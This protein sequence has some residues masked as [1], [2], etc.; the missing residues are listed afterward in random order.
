MQCDYCNNWHHQI[1]VLFNGR[2]NEGGEAPFTCPSCIMS[3]LEKKERTPTTTR[4]SSQL[5]ANVL[6]QTRLSYFLEERLRKVLSHERN[7]RA[8]LLGKPLEEVPSAEGLTIRVVSS[9]DKKLETKPGFYKAFKDQNYPAE[10]P[11]RSKVLLLFQKIEGV[12]VCLLGIYVQEYGSDCP[13]PNNRRVYLSYL[14]SVKYFRP[15]GIQVATGEGCALRTYCYHQILI[16]YLQYIKQ[17][18]FT[19]C[20]I[21][22]CPPFQG[23]DYI[24]YCHPKE[25]KTPKSEKLREWYLKMLRQAQKEGIVLSLSNLYDEFH[26]GNQNHDIASAAE[27]PYFDGDYFPG[28][29]EDWIPGIQK[30]Q[31][32]AAKKNKG[33]GGK[34]ATAAARKTGKGKRLGAGTPEAELDLELMKKLGTTIANMRQDFIMVHLA[35]QC[36]QCRK[37]IADD[38]RWYDSTPSAT[39]TVFELCQ[40]CYDVEQALPAHEKLLTGGR[41]LVCERVNEL[42]DMRE[43]GEVMESEFFDSRQAFLSLCQGNHFQFDSLRRA[44]HTT[45]MVLYHLNNPSEPAFVATC[46]VCQRELEPG[47]GWRCE[48]CSDYDICEECKMTVGHEHGL[49]KA[50]RA[51]GDRGSGMTQED[52][53]DRAAQIQRTMELLVHATSCQ[54]MNCGNPNCT[55]VKHLFKHAMACQLK[56]GGGCQLCRKM[57]TLLQMHSKG[58]KTA[59]CPVPRCRDLKEYRRRAQ[60]QVEERRREHYRMYMNKQNAVAVAGR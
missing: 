8:K 43:D 17:R 37:C 45:M 4:P 34:T 13:A 42:P 31:A 22:A 26:L 6:P 5:P 24:L 16:G 21:W 30:E 18:G 32:E 11:Y 36:V 53:R 39:G 27:L 29:A 54:V 10:F 12:D 60:E 9:V 59:N 20:F 40:E 15:S 46:N 49:V 52:R 33:K 58:C 23:E 2:R 7:E 35:H 55:K 57:W 51:A 44:K 48:T 25:Q 3:Q 1:C 56:A 14:D 41:D 28:V 47:K 38:N 19:S 50:G